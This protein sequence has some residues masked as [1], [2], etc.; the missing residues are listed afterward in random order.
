MTITRG[1]T[2]G[3]G[4]HPEGLRSTGPP[5]GG[6]ALTSPHATILPV[7]LVSWPG[8]SKVRTLSLGLHE[9]IGQWW[10]TRT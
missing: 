1:E 8:L 6:G 9:G 2:A 7:G 3:P 5:S 10:S 4:K